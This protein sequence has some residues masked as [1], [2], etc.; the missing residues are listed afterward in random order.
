MT[1]TAKKNL[2]FKRPLVSV[3]TVLAVSDLKSEDAVLEAIDDG[4]LLYAFDIARP[5]ANRRLVR[6]LASSVVDFVEGRKPPNNSEAQE[7]QKVLRQI[8]PVTSPTIVAKEIAIAWN[9]SS[10]HIINLIEQKLLRLDA[11][12]SPW[13]GGRGGSPRVEYA[14]ATDFLKTRRLC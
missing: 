8:F 2:E 12:G 4:R 10:T 9:V 7:W 13:H 11:N 14:S 6:V 3:W 5:N 1:V